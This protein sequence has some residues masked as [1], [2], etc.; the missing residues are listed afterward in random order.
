MNSL[1]DLVDHFKLIHKIN[2]NNIDI[3]LN[4]YH[5]RPSFNT[6]FPCQYCS[7]KFYSRFEL[8]QH[9]AHEHQEKISD[10]HENEKKLCKMIETVEYLQFFTTHL[11]FNRY[12]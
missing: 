5:R 7:K 8:N 9:L 1:N 4:N 3:H 6:L 11:D 2:N 12:Q 10:W